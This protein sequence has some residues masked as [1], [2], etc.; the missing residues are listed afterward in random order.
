MRISKRYVALALL[1][2]AVTPCAAQEGRGDPKDTEAIAKNAEGFVEAFHKGDAKAIAAFWAPDGD[3]TPQTGV[4]IKG[5]Q[6]IEKAFQ[7]FFADNKDIKVRIDSH[8]LRFITPDVAVE[9]GVTATRPAEGGPPRRARYTIIH[10]KKDGRWYLSS[11]RDAV[12]IPPSNRDSLRNLEWLSGNWSADVA[13]GEVEK[14]SFAWTLNDNFVLGHFTTTFGNMPVAA[15]TQFIGWDPEAKGIRS[16][17]FDAAGGLG[18][19]TWT[20]EG[21]KWIVKSSLTLHDGKKAQV[22]YVLAHVDD[23]T[24][25][26]QAKDRSVEG[27]SIPDG[28]ETRLKRVK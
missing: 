2:L 5:R 13:K 20:H 19:G 18:Q 4:H 1:G 28:P 14:L 9:D 10:A 15:A 6:A 3:Y 7:E 12:F 17:T 23:D 22:T 25:T 16:W 27:K 8:S 24:I 21:K 11:V 26:L